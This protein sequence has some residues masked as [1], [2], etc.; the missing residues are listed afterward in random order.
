MKLVPRPHCIRKIRNETSFLLISKISKA[1][2]AITA[3]IGKPAYV[4]FAFVML[5]AF[6]SNTLA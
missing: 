1:Y 6:L 5:S 4:N 3:R 2:F